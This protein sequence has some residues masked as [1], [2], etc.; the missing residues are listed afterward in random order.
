MTSPTPFPLHC[1]RVR[2]SLVTH[3]VSRT[4]FKMF[5]SLDMAVGYR[6]VPQ[7]VWRYHAHAATAPPPTSAGSA[8]RRCPV[9]TTD[10]CPPPSQAPIACTFLLTFQLNCIIIIVSRGQNLRCMSTLKPGLRVSNVKLTL[11]YVSV[12]IP[13]SHGVH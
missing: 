10:L 3:F 13:L 5:M 12:L 7:G 8:Q 2:G 4:P 9:L 1:V 11:A 6:E